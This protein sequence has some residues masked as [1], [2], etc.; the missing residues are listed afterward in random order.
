L[1]CASISGV[2]DEVVKDRDLRG[3]QGDCWWSVWDRASNHGQPHH[4]PA[5]DAEHCD[6]IRQPLCGAQL[7]VF[8]ATARLQD[9]VEYLNL[10]TQGVPSDLLNSLFEALHVKVGQEFPD[11]WLAPRRRV[12][13]GCVDHA[14][15]ER[16]VSLLLS[17]RRQNK[18]PLEPDLQGGLAHLVLITAHLDLK[19]SGAWRRL[20]F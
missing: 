6:Q 17:D 20:H 16:G 5:Y 19:N 8:G 9:F 11:D 15:F 10:P 3:R 1:F 2:A 4:A 18:H 13:F 14:Q 7:G 12:D